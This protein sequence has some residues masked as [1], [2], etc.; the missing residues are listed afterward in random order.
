M[1]RLFEKLIQN[2]Y[3]GN[4]HLYEEMQQAK[5]DADYKYFHHVKDE[6]EKGIRTPKTHSI[7]EWEWVGR[8]KLCQ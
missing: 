6:W 2:I 1:S 5:L 8:P 4:P 7:K 3:C